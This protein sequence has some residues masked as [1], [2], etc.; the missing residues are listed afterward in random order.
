MEDLKVEITVDD[1]VV[2]EAPFGF[3]AA[4]TFSVYAKIPGGCFVMDYVVAD[5]LTPDVEKAMKRM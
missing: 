2:E 3:G 5:G 4:R 1:V